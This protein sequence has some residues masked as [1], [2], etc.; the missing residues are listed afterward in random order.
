MKHKYGIL[1]TILT[2]IL[3]MGLLVGCGTD[4]S[5]D[6]DDDYS[7]SYEDESTEES[8]ESDET[9]TGETEDVI[10]KITYVSDSYITI[11]TY[12]TEEDVEDYATLDTSALS[13]DGLTNYVYLDD[14]TEVYYVSYETLYSTTQDDLEIGTMIAVTED[15]DGIQQVI[16]LEYAE[17]ESTTEEDTSDE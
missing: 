6:T 15:S 9:L 5:T 14:T 7:Y 1:A 16:I 4:S 3:C 10:G 2:M 13:S 8:D 17:E 12:A 11:E